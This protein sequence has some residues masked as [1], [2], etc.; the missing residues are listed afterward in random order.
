MDKLYLFFCRDHDNPIIQQYSPKVILSIELFKGTRVQNG[1]RS[2]FQS[3]A[4][5]SLYILY[6]KCWC[7]AIFLEIWEPRS[8]PP[9][10]QDK[11][12]QFVSDFKSP[13]FN[14]L[15]FF[16]LASAVELFYLLF[17]FN[18]SQGRSTIIYLCNSVISDSIGGTVQ[19]LWLWGGGLDLDGQ[20]NF[21]TPPKKVT[22]L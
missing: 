11:A 21:S 7:A 8:K 16:P 1:V 4:C 9:K 3:Y 2:E 15:F 6:G 14:V 5:T 12:L 13:G 22:G 19:K 17:S 10:F 18:K 20:S